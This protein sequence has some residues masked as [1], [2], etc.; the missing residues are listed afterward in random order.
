MSEAADPCT[1]AVNFGLALPVHDWL[2][3]LLTHWVYCVKVGSENSLFDLD[4]QFVAVFL[5]VVVSD[6]TEQVH[7]EVVLQS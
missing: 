2:M 3:R 1:E 5:A 4:L 7:F 6:L